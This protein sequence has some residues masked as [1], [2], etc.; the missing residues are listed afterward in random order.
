M[1]SSTE[2]SEE[3][4][5]KGGTRLFSVTERERQGLRLQYSQ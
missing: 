5:R 4:A 3:T 1:S 2:Y